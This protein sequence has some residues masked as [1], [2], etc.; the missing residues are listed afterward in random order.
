MPD[1]PPT[2]SHQEPMASPRVLP[3]SLGTPPPRVHPTTV[4]PKVPGILPTRVPFSVQNFLFPWE[5]SSVGPGQN[6]AVHQLGTEPRFSTNSNISHL[7]IPMP[8]APTSRQIKPHEPSS[9]LT[10]LC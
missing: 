4:S 6:I 10:K 1:A 2:H 9:L 8:A 3:T 7:G 5:V